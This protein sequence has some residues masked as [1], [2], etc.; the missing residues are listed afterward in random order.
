MCPNCPTNHNCPHRRYHRQIPFDILIAH[1]HCLNKPNSPRS[2]PNTR[3]IHSLVQEMPKRQVNISKCNKPRIKTCQTRLQFPIQCSTPD[4]R[5][6]IKRQSKGF[7]ERQISSP[8]HNTCIL[9]S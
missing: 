3:S 5:Q 6:P 7:K 4:K 1:R 9:K 8:I 2:C